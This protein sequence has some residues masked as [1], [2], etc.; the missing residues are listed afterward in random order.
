VTLEKNLKFKK[1][2]HDFAR[3]KALSVGLLCFAISGLYLFV[4]EIN[5]GTSVL[6]AIMLIAVSVGF[7][8]Y[9][10]S[11]KYVPFLFFRKRK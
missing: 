2:K 8:I 1:E 11:G 7:L 5:K 9:G 3:K 4:P 10:I 6:R